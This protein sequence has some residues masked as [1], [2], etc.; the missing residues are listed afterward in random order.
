[1][2][3]SHFW[4]ISR[5]VRLGTAKTYLRFLEEFGFVGIEIDEELNKNKIVFVD[6]WGA[7]YDAKDA[8]K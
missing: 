5:G 7:K 1:M 8:F 6:K 2:L 3:G 4:G